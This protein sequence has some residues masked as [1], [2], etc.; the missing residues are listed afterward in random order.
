MAPSRVL[1]TGQKPQAHGS[2]Q[3]SC[4]EMASSNPIPAQRQWIMERTAKGRVFSGPG[5]SWF[6]FKA[7]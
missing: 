1:C 5:G 4:H 3:A 2:A 7:V 6:G